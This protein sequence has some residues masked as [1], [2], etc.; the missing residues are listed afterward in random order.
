MAILWLHLPH[1]KSQYYSTLGNL[2]GLVK[3]LTSLP[4]NG[5]QD[6]ETR[7]TSNR[8]LGDRPNSRDGRTLSIGA[9]GYPSLTHVIQVLNPRASWRFETLT[10]APY[11]LPL[12]LPT[13]SGLM[14]CLYYMTLSE[15]GWNFVGKEF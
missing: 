7:E 15:K 14:P 10:T 12:L 13:V 6:T 5:L 4:E 9:D 1:R 11:H 2:A 3:F 8:V